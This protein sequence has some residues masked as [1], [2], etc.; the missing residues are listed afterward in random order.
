[1]YSAEEVPGSPDQDL[2]LWDEF[3]SEDRSARKLLMVCSYLKGP[4]AS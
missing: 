1:M 4:A 3:N 2:R